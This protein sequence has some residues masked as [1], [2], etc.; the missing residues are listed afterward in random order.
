MPINFKLFPRSRART[1][2]C[3]KWSRLNQSPFRHYHEVVCR[4]N[5]DAVQLWLTVTLKTKVGSTWI[6]QHRPLAVVVV[7]VV[8]YQTTGSCSGG[9]GDMSDH[10]ELQWWRWLYIRP[11]GVAVVAVVVCQTTGSCS[12]GG[13]D[14]SDHQELWWWRWWYVCS[15]DVSRLNL[16][17]LPSVS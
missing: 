7:A 12:G 11:P 13:G 1:R 4:F 14:M 3:E 8:V 5:K 6:S 10:Q 17:V 9:G 16:P 2:P 15:Y